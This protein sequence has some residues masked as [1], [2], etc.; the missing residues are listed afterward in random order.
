MSS[1]A[2]IKQAD[3][4]RLLAAVRKVGLMPAK[5]QLTPERGLELYFNA[6]TRAPRGGE[7]VELD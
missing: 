1:P 6:D 4:E 3:A 2:L 7:P 5:M